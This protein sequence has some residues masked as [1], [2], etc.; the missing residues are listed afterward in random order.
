MRLTYPKVSAMNP[1]NKT[2]DV[3]NDPKKSKLP[4]KNH[5]VQNPQHLRPSGF[6][7]IKEIKN[8]FKRNK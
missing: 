7:V 2:T 3:G 5:H 4:A 6:Q 1:K 8:N